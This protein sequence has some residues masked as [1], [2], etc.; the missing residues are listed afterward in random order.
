[1]TETT[2]LDALFGKEGGFRPAVQ[3][4]D[5]TWDFATMYGI[6][7]HV[8]GQW[9]GLGRHATVAE[10]Q[11]MPITEA[12]AIYRR[13]YIHAPGFTAEA[14]G[15]EPLR[16]QLIDFGVNSG[17]PR[18]IRWLQRVLRQVRPE[19]AVDGVLGPQTR[20]TLQECRGYLP[21]VHD[22]LVAARSYMVDRAV[23][24]GAL[25]KQDEEGLES[26]ALSFLLAKPD[27]S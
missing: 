4:P 7:A 18:A 10:L 17:P 13:E 5:G 16:L 11:A 27:E 6:T 8:L 19:I 3:R 25:R 2:I 9:R 14:I 15:F 24:T 1:M 12:A 22:A 26:R 20:R 21:W 23:D